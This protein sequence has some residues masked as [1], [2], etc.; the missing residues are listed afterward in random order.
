MTVK[1]VKLV[2]GK[3]QV[4]TDIETKWYDIANYLQAS[5]VP[6]LT[7]SSLGLLTTL[8]QVVI[9]LVQEL[10]EKELL[11][12]DFVSGFDLQ[13]VYDTLIDDLSAEAI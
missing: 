5:D 11:G 4:E 1:N 12:E 8:A 2:N 10:Q 6:D 3:L 7:I 13:Y 9:V